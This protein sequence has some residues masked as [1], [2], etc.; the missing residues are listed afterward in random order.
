QAA[1]GQSDN[2]FTPVQIANYMATV[3]NGGTNYQVHLLK[4][5]K[6]NTEDVILEEKP[7]KIRNQIAI[8][9]ENLEAVLNGM[10][11]VTS[12]GTARAAFAGFPIQ[13]GGKTGSAQVS[14]GSANAIYVGYAPYDNPQI[15]VAVVLEHGYS[16]GNAS[17]IARD[18][19]Q[20]YFFGAEKNVE[21]TMKNTLLP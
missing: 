21:K 12:E 1:I 11:L 2:L 10:Q 7:A 6:S 17:F 4:A 13:T 5:V 16:G 8:K 20:E 15:A 14:S 3:A 9:P 18:I 19:F